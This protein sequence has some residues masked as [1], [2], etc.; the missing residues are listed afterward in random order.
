MLPLAVIR[1]GVCAGK[2]PSVYAG[3]EEEADTIN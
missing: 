3:K 2:G 1:Q